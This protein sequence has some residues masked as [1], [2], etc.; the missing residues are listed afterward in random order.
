MLRWGC[1]SEPSGWWWL[2]LGAIM[3]V[4]CLAPTWEVMR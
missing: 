4:A 2:L 1:R 3:V